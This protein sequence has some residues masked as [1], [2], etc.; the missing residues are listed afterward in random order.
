MHVS[1]HVDG[2]L[3]PAQM[4]IILRIAKQENFSLFLSDEFYTEFGCMPAEHAVRIV[5][6]STRAE[7]YAFA[8]ASVPGLSVTRAKQQTASYSMHSANCDRHSFMHSLE[9]ADVCVRLHVFA[10]VSKRYTR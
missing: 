7:S 6:A 10:G 9:C 3:G 2:C 8:Y 4:T 5:A 1:V